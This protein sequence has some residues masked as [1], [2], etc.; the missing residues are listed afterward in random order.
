LTGAAADLIHYD[1]T[2][3]PRDGRIIRALRA[4]LKAGGNSGRRKAM[5]LILDMPMQDNAFSPLI[6]D[7]S[8]SNNNANFGAINTSDISVPGP[9]GVLPRALNFGLAALNPDVATFTTGIELNN[10]N[11][12]ICFFAKL[13][14]ATPTAPILG[15]DADF[16]W[17]LLAQGPA[18]LELQN[19]VGGSS[20]PMSVDPQSWHH[21]GLT[22]SGGN[23]S[24]F[25]DGVADGDFASVMVGQLQ[26][27]KIGNNADIGPAFNLLMAGLKIYDEVRA[28]PQILTDYQEGVDS[29]TWPV[30]S[31]P[32][33]TWPDVTW[34]HATW[35][36][37]GWPQYGW[38]R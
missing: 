20:N 29:A 25:V 3:A 24:L 19:L 2:A 26:V 4:G 13:T 9:G 1:H 15:H 16:E 22:N 17:L 23:W 28:A 8:A 7:I 10:A 33:L 37:A 6:D 14:D 31:W 12:T 30:G 21:Y 32:H 5:T 27:H 34:P 18:Q 11:R 36:H 38:P 35:P